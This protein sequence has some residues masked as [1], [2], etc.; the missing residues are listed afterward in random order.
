MPASHWNDQ[1]MLETLYGLRD[2][3][4]HLLACPDCAARMEQLR[5]RRRATIEAPELSPHF[6]ARQ[7]RDIYARLDSPGSLARRS[8]YQPAA[9]L[10][11]LFVVAVALWRPANY[12]SHQVPAEDQKLSTEI[13]YNV[14]GG[15]SDPRIYTEIYQVVSSD[16]PKAAE[17]IQA[18][19]ED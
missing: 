11:A 18:L 3:D 16:V 4:A 14:G 9:A 1:D 7:R 13:Y 8:F 2:G 19:F 6:L 12:P 5:A 15:P 10:A 17:P